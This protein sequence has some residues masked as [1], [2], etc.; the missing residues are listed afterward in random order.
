MGVPII[1]ILENIFEAAADFV[2]DIFQEDGEKREAFTQNC[3][4][5]ALA[6]VPNQNV[7]VIHPSHSVS[8]VYMHSHY[9]LG[10]TVGTCGYDIYVSKPGDPFDLVNQGDGGYI[11]WCFSGYNRDG[12]H[13]WA[14]AAPPPPTSNLT[15]WTSFISTDPNHA[16][17][18]CHSADGTNWTGSTPTG[19][20]S[21]VAPSLAAYNNQLYVAYVA[22]NG[23]NN[24]YVTSTADG[25]NWTGNTKTGQSSSAAPSL[26][27]F[28]GQLHCV[29][30]AV[31]AGDPPLWICSSDNGVNWSNNT[32]TGQLSATAPSLAGNV[33]TTT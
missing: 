6:Q 3:V 31:V 22:D 13:I 5:Q 30:V 17:L 14:D 23:T 7:V 26:A 8:G 2:E 27:A 25:A 15:L 11:N 9:E 16:V 19:Q 21:S 4:E 1:A 28:N 12:N 32:N 10:M 33:S 20:Y 29:Y 24:L 18:V